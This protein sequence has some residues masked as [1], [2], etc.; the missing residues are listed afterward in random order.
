[1][2]C[3]VRF[4]CLA[5]FCLWA[6]VVKASTILWD[7]FT[8]EK[9]DGPDGPIYELHTLVYNARGN[10]SG[11]LYSDLWLQAIFHTTRTCFLSAVVQQPVLWYG[12]NWIWWWRG[13]PV[14]G[15]W[16]RN[17][18]R[19]SSGSVGYFYH[20]YMDEQDSW[21]LTEYSIMCSNWE[22]NEKTVFLACALAMDIMPYV[23]EDFYNPALMPVYG[24][25]E[26]AVNPTSREVRLVHSAVDV[27]GDAILCGVY[28]PPAPEPASGALLLSGC[29]LLCARRR[30]RAAVKCCQCANVASCQ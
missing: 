20:V 24:W 23:N 14:D 11:V 6:F 26:L 9:F 28:N 17:I 22:S 15:L 30:R 21:P 12:E 1:M 5:V 4:V 19:K 25:V 2:I 13:Y 29:L 16:T 27:D 7:P 8:L 10:D 3:L 18:P